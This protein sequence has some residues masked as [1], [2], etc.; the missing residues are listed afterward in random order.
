L[1][2]EVIETKH[3]GRGYQVPEPVGEAALEAYQGAMAVLEGSGA[4]DVLRAQG[5]EGL[6]KAA[7]L[8]A[9]H[10]DSRA[11]VERLLRK[12]KI[13]G[14]LFEPSKWVSLFAHPKRFLE[15]YLLAIG[16]WY[17]LGFLSDGVGNETEN[18]AE[19]KSESEESQQG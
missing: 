15:P 5:A 3:F 7:R 12:A 4:G 18:D 17:K 9:G 16:L 6:Q 10:P 1:G 14:V 13:D 19:K 11:I 2:V 8:I